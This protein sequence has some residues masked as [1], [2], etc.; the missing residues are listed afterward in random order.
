MRSVYEA[1][2][3][4]GL[5][6]TQVTYGTLIARAGKWRESRSAV[7]YY[8]DMV[9]RG[10]RPDA[11]THNSLINAF[12]KSGDLTKACQ[13]ASTMAQRGLQPTLV[14]CIHLPGIEPC[15]LH[16][17]LSGPVLT[18]RGRQHAARRLRARWQPHAGKGH[19]RRD[20]KR[21]DISI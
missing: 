11:Q 6:P 1:M 4:S 9:R 3:A 10:V 8:R 19:A 15:S 12:V 16:A 14:T 13:V 20:A 21:G 18:S 5:R 7:S 17:E 2:V